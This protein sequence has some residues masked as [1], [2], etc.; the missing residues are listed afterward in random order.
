MDPTGLPGELAAEL[1]KLRHSRDDALQAARAAVRDASRVSRLLTVLNEPAPIDSLLDNILNTISEIFSADVVTLTDVAGTGHFYPVASV[2]MPEDFVF[3]KAWLADISSLYDPLR[4]GAVLTREMI[5][6]IPVLDELARQLT[7]ESIVWIP[8]KGDR[9]LRGALAL[10][11]CAPLPFT[12]EEIALLSTMAYRIAVTLEQMQRKNQLELIIRGNKEIIGRHMQQLA[13]EEEATRTFPAIVGADA[14]I[15][16]RCSDDCRILCSDGVETLNADALDWPL[17]AR[18]LSRHPAIRAGESVS[19]IDSDRSSFPANCPNFPFAAMLVS[20]I[21]REGRLENLICALRTNAV[22]FGDGTKQMAMLYSGHLASALE[23]AHLYGALRNELHERKLIEASLRES[24]ERFKALVR[25]ISDVIAVLDSDGM[26]RYAGDAS[27]T[28]WGHAPEAF[29]GTRLLDRAHPDD[30]ETL[31]AVIADALKNPKQNFR[32][33]ARMRDGESDAWRFFDV[34]VSNL[35]HDAA[36]NG[37]V[38]TFHDITERKIY[39]KELSELA[40]RDPLTGLANRANFCDRVRFALARA[41][42]RNASAVIIFFDLDNFKS[43]NDTFGHTAGDQTLRT[44]AERVLGCLRSNDM[45]ARLGGDEFTILIEHIKAIDH[46]LPV[47]E[48]LLSVLMEPIRLNGVDVN[49]GG[50]IGVAI[51]VPNEDNVESLL[52][53]A[54]QAMYRAKRSGKGR[55]VFFDPDF[56]DD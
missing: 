18:H 36:V 33:V 26:I 12:R 6:A 47:V 50:S 27:R 55:Y 24:E 25:N 21:F 32:T 51:S 31:A 4:E 54:D 46:S 45:A 15:F 16:F 56:V 20:P 1:E 5:R 38:S 39:E 41:N 29:V 30:F 8:M 43:I 11:R 42:E 44:V 14:A 3:E 22:D 52:H 28:L 19:F 48:R 37:I 49:I 9:G 7:F 13:I 17:L 2:G 34:I 23:N 53:K 35:L 10:A 40:F